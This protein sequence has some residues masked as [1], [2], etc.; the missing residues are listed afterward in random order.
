MIAVFLLVLQSLS[1]VCPGGIALIKHFEGFERCASPDPIGLPTIG[2]G[3]LCKKNDPV[4]KR[5]FTEPEAAAFLIEDL[6]TYENCVQKALGPLM[7]RTNPAQ[8]AAMVSFT[9]NLGCGGFQTSTFLKRMKGGEA[10]SK[11]VKSEF[12]K[13]VNA[14]GRPFSG[15]VRR[16]TEESDLFNGRGKYAASCGGS[17]TSYA[18]PTSKSPVTPANKYST[19]LPGLSYGSL[20]LASV[21][22]VNVGGKC[23]KAA[24]CTGSSLSVPSFCPG[25]AG[26]ECCVQVDSSAK[27]TF[28]ENK[29]FLGKSCQAPLNGVTSKGTCRYTSLC[30]NDGSV[31]VPGFCPG[32]TNIQCCVGTPKTKKPS[33][34]LPQQPPKTP[35]TPKPPANQPPTN[36]TPE[37]PS[38]DPVA[39]SI[40]SLPKKAAP[41]YQ[42]GSRIGTINVVTIQNKPVEIKTAIRYEQMRLAAKRDGNNLRIISGF[43]DNSQ[44]VRLYNMY[45]NGRGNLAARPGYSNHQNGIA[46]DLNPEE[47]N[48]YRWL[49][50]NASKYG[51]CRTVPSERWHWEYLP[52]NKGRCIRA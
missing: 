32:A 49:A 4:C 29:P 22:N 14:G 43:R 30:A 28:V 8:Y 39:K 36:P 48:N 13:F 2:Y 9:F 25:Q 19:I 38:N 11:Y 20:C 12:G 47:G 42:K 27:K 17:G 45:K 3:H 40:Y 50:K 18:P 31:S 15:L 21:N 23:V 10:P 26:L 41:A 24:Q 7:S 46:L 35:N 37:I 34:F 16:R 1:A 6:K 52:V 51:F 33:P 5:C 44:Q